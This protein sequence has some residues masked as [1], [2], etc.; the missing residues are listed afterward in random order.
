MF[1][2]LSEHFEIKENGCKK[3]LVSYNKIQHNI[4]K[5]AQFAPRW[6]EVHNSAEKLIKK[7]LLLDAGKEMKI[8]LAQV[9]S[10]SDVL[11]IAIAGQVERLL[12][13]NRIQG[14]SLMDE[15]TF[16]TC[17]TLPFFEPV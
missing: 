3:F 1:C 7:I 14:I 5:L 4:Q 15:R 2:N 10:A 11:S 12:F 6:Y 8:F 13:R 9:Q 17:V 16:A